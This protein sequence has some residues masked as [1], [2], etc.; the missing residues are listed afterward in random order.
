MKMS[1]FV[2]KADG[3]VQLFDRRKAIRTCSRI[4][5]SRRIAVEVANAVEARVYDGIPTQKVLQMIFELLREHTP[6]ILHFFDLKEGLSLMSS[7]PE[8]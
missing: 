6:T 8:F 4:G 3:S 1:V 2:T 7:K 5:V